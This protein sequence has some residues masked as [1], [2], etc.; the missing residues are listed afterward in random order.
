VR[1]RSAGS[2]QTRPDT[3]SHSPEHQGHSEHRT[4]SASLCPRGVSVFERIGTDSIAGRRSGSV[5]RRVR[6]LI[7]RGRW[8]ASVT[9]EGWLRR[10]RSPRAGAGGLRLRADLQ[11]VPLVAP[12]LDLGH[13]SM[14]TMLMCTRSESAVDAGALCMPPS[15]RA[16][17]L[18]AAQNAERGSTEDV[19]QRP[20]AAL[21]RHAPQQT[22]PTVERPQ[23]GDR[24]ERIRRHDS[25]LRR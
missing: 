12:G 5:R 18:A 19:R 11:N 25:V 9:G 23:P 2:T 8:A 22:A 3:P 24:P 21:R 4:S 14:P 20:G 1:G 13:I 17:P 10:G 16:A 15:T 6:T 7:A